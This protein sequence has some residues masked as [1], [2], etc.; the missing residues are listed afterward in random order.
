M[1]CVKSMFCILIVMIT[2]CCNNFEKIGDLPDCEKDQIFYIDNDKDGFGDLEVSIMGCVL[3]EGYSLNG[4]DCNDNDADVFKVAIYHI[5]SDGDGF[6]D[7][8]HEIVACSIPNGAVNNSTDCNDDDAE[9]HPRAA[10]LCDDIDNDCDEETDE[11]LKLI[12]SYLDADEDGFGDANEAQT[13]KCNVPDGNVIMIGDCNDNDASIAPGKDDVCDDVDND[14]DGDTDEDSVFT[15]YYIDADGDGFGDPNK[16]VSVC[17][18]LEVH[19][20]DDTDCD[21]SDE[22]GRAH[23]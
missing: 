8:A 9:I 12:I 15:T 20:L 6:G 2:G 7:L 13:L 19:L 10:E 16:E 5:D 22:I 18:Q 17:L 1:R 3:P 4:D 11:D 14:C 21:D 23:V